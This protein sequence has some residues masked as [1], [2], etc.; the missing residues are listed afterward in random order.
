VK[1]FCKDR[2]YSEYAFYTWRKRLRN[3][4]PVRFALLQRGAVRN[5]PATDVGL[6]L[7]LM[8]GERLR[9]GKQVEAAKL[10]MV[11]DVVRG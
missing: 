9:I 7:V 6:E 4:E 11:L 1:Q 10:R 2:G 8:T 3:N 5:E